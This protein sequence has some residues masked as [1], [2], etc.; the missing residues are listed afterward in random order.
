MLTHRENLS[1]MK[2]EPQQNQCMLLNNFKKLCSREL[3]TYHISG[4]KSSMGEVE[5]WYQMV[6]EV[7]SNISSWRFMRH[8]HPLNSQRPP[9][10]GMIDFLE[11]SVSHVYWTHEHVFQGTFFFFFLPSTELLFHWTLLGK[12]GCKAPFCPVVKR[13]CCGALWQRSPTWPICNDF[14]KLGK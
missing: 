2:E 14:P 4:G 12:V 6:W 9:E 10:R 8:R 1:I 5:F 13:A 7:A 3:Q 11:P